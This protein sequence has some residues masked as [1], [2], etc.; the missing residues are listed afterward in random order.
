MDIETLKSLGFVRKSCTSCGSAFWTLDSGR[1][2]CGDTECDG[3]SFIG[4]KVT[5]KRYNNNEMRSLFVNFFKKDHTFLEPYPVVPRWREDVLLVNASIY[6]FQPHVTSG[7]VKPPANPI[8]MSQPCIRMID[9]DLVGETG[10]HLTSFEMM[11]HDSFNTPKESV[12]WIDGTVERSYNFFTRGMGITPEYLTYKEKPWSGGGNGGEAVEVFARGLEVATLVFMNM[13]IDPAGSVEIDGDH[14]SRMGMEIVDTGY[15]LERSSWL[16]YGTPT[17]YD[18]LYPQVIRNVVESSGVEPVDQ[19]LMAHVTNLSSKTG[20]FGVN[21]LAKSL[22]ESEGVHHGIEELKSEIRRAK[23]IYTVADH[24]RS[25]LFMLSNYVIPSNVKVG[26]LARILLRRT[27]RNLSVLGS[28]NIIMDLLEIH[29]KNFS[30]ILK[31][32]PWNFIR[33]SIEEESGKYEAAL[34][35][36]ESIVSRIIEKSGTVTLQD[37]VKLYDSHGLDPETVSRIAEKHGALLKVP[38]NFQE[39]IVKLHDQGNGRKKEGETYPELETRPLYYDD[40]SILDFTAIVLYSSDKKVILNQTAFYPEG[41][42]QPCDQG[43]LDLGSRKVKVTYV[44]K[45]GKTIIHHVSENIPEKTRLSGHVEPYRRRRLMLHHSATHL[46]L[47][48]SR[49]ILGDHVWQAGAQKG[50][51]ESRIDI[52]HFSKLT[53]SEIEKIEKRCLDYIQEGRSITVRNIDWFKAVDKYGFTLFQGGTP[54]D[55]KLRVVEIEGVDAE[56]CGGTHMKN[57][58]Q[59]GFIKIIRADAVQEGIQRLIFCA[60]DA[61]IGYVQKLYTSFRQIQSSLGSDLDGTLSSFQKIYNENI[62]QGKKLEFLRKEKVNGLLSGAS[63]FTSG[64]NTVALIQSVLDDQELKLI[65]KIA[66]TDRGE[67]LVIA[68]LLDGGYRYTVVDPAGNSLGRVDALAGKIEMLTSNKIMRVFTTRM[69]PGNL[70]N[71]ILNESAK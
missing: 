60:G 71:F 69:E 11:C 36:G 18:F 1:M 23:A 17:I 49:E 34:G 54:L 65:T 10:R 55:S 30:A 12:Y 51:E 6:D 48:V 21:E 64:G 27:L 7:Y 5:S 20:I 52:T 19:D 31:D 14:Y 67:A 42:G 59:L 26:Y 61:A 38:A 28:D 40:T 63:K 46:L 29:A 4:Q 68:A 44:Q 57:T 24:T 32:P 43:Y 45:K 16:S 66:A 35:R 3:Y 9:V 39:E 2:T 8:V 13:K 37:A 58:N 33:Q 70:I 41:G 47:A 25:I 53:A 56:G 22:H 62:E 50:V 15:G